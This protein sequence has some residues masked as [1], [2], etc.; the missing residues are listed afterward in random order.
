MSTSMIFA[1][2]PAPQVVAALSGGEPA[3]LAR[4]PT[5]DFSLHLDLGVFD[6]LMAAVAEH[7]GVA[8]RAFFDDLLGDHLWDEGDASADLCAP[9]FAQLWARVE[10]PAFLAVARG[11][12]G[13]DLT[14]EL[15]AA[16]AALV[17]LC[18]ALAPGEDVVFVV[19]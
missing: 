16:L 11:W 19:G 5:A 18:R 3:A 4:F 1:A 14:P 15:E 10:L 9:E 17:T 7:L 13:K 8:R 2:A 6:D 12:L